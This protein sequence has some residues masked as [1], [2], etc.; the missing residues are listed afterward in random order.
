MWWS[1]SYSKHNNKYVVIHY[2]CI[3]AASSYLWVCLLTHCIRMRIRRKARDSTTLM[4]LP[5]WWLRQ[6]SLLIYTEKKYYW[7]VFRIH[8]YSWHNLFSASFQKQQIY[9]YIHHVFVSCLY[10]TL[11]FWF[12]C[13]MRLALFAFAETEPSAEKMFISFY[14]DCQLPES[15][16]CMH[17]VCPQRC[18]YVLRVAQTSA[19][20]GIIVYYP[21]V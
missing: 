20:F 8:D 13:S 6:F 19:M 17:S 12:G 5:R 4:H 2:N 15:A 21:H 10:D 14:C 1:F 16:R 3:C 11:F 9:L 18:V 7:K